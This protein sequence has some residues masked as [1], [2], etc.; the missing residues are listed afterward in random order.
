MSGILV[1]SPTLTSLANPSAAKSGFSIV[2]VDG[3]YPSFLRRA[4]FTC[5]GSVSI[6]RHAVSGAGAGGGRVGWG[7]LEEPRVVEGDALRA[8][9]LWVLFAVASC[10]L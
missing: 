6:L 9:A 8:L 5:A 2:G 4:H 3:A 10:F 1:S 7:G